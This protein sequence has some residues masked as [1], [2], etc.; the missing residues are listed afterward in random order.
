[1]TKRSVI[2]AL[3][4][5]LFSADAF[6]QQQSLTEAERRSLE[7]TIYADD[8]ALISDRRN[9][10]LEAGLNRLV[11][12]DVSDRIRPE[13]AALGSLS[14]PGS[15]AV[16]QM[17]Y[18]ADLLT[19]RALLERHLGRTVGVV[20]VDPATGEETQVEAQLLSVADGVVLRIGDRIETAPEGR[21]VFSEVPDGLRGRPALAFEAAAETPGRHELEL[22][23]LATGLSWQSDYMAELSADADRLR[24]LGSFTIVNRSA[25]RY[26]EARLQLV[27]GSLHRVRDEVHLRR[28]ARELMAVAAPEVQREA[29]LDY[30]LY[31][32]TPPVTLEPNQ[33]RQVGFVD[34]AEVPA[35]R[36]HL[37]VGQEYHYRGRHGQ[38]GRDLPVATFVELDN[39]AQGGL[40]VPLP[41]GVVRVYQPDSA[42]RIHLVGEDRIGH[43]PDG[44]T[45]R[46]QLGHAFD[47]RADRVQ[48][49]FVRLPAPEREQRFESAFRIAVRNA[50][51]REVTVTILEPLPGEWE[52]VEE[53][54][55]HER[56]S[57]REA[58]WRL[59]V[60][61]RG[62]AALEFR[63][64]VR[65]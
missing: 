5:L 12:E 34:A 42:G 33:M 16:R 56:K 45:L 22:R 39:R 21:I 4:L 38:L 6:A 7:I 35:R 47:L 31:T 53:S 65:L 10:E 28:D 64:R 27:A 30:H 32:L 41:S 48:T 36:E 44:E 8:L 1:M 17:S 40:G 50:G 2:A 3:L 20:R 54:H 9:A 13:S 52:V 24:L 14:R 15:V 63:V 26:P 43:T 49:D 19:P 11:F 60:P 37:L 59:A 46:L 51:D 29:L 23:Y 57:A 62:E 25:V 61:P 18:D 58:Q 55:P